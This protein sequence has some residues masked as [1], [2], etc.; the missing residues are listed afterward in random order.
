MVQKILQ[1]EK[2][3]SIYNK[4]NSSNFTILAQQFSDGALNINNWYRESALNAE[5]IE[6]YARI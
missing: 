2:I 6:S 3:N 4:A 1:E 5:V